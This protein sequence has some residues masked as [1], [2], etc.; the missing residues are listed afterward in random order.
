MLG[1]PLVRS[2]RRA[3]FSV[4]AVAFALCIIAGPA[5]ATGDLPRLAYPEAGRL[6][7]GSHGTTGTTAEHRRAFELTG[8]TGTGAGAI[9]LPPP[10]SPYQ[11]N[12]ASHMV[13]NDNWVVLPN[14]TTVT[15]GFTS[16]KIGI[17]AF[18]AIQPAINAISAGGT[19]DVLPGA[20][21]ETAANSFLYDG[22]GPYTFGLFFAQ[23]KGAIKL[24]GVTA[25]GVVITS[26][27]ATQA[28]VTT[29]SDA[30]SSHSTR[31]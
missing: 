15:V 27:A 30:N 22:N 3:Q 20:Y 19:I 7:P 4:A 17:D 11:I 14:G 8:K 18:A 26:A 6:G 10:K 12:S 13:V 9:S 28:T 21:S 29:N 5:S 23:A 2:H 1:W 31:R 24:Q 25:T 16:Y